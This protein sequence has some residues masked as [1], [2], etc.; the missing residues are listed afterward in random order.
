ME[1]SKTRCRS[2]LIVEDDAVDVRI[3]SECIINLG[4]SVEMNTVATG[5]DAIAYLKREGPHRDARRPE[6]VLLD[7]NLPAKSGFEVL[8]EIRADKNLELLPVVMLSSSDMPD[9]VKGAY[10]AGCN[11]YITKPPGLKEFEQAMADFAK[12]WF[13]TA[14]VPS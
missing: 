10:Q 5:P 12:F 1:T 13:H 6:F 8:R 4:L 11:A 14:V 9:D 2:I 7:V 3:I